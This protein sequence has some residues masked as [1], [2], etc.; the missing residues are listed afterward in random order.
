MFSDVLREEEA[1]DYGA[2]E[3]DDNYNHWCLPAIRR[4][5]FYR[6]GMLEEMNERHGHLR[7]LGG[8]AARIRSKF[9]SV[10]P[11]VVHEVPLFAVFR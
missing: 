8:T 1:S 9:R 11:P 3:N 7:S 5:V 4:R 10:W 6:L 2:L